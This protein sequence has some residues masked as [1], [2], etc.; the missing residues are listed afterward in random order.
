MGV[1][2]RKVKRNVIAISKV[3]SDCAICARPLQPANQKMQA[4]LKSEEKASGITV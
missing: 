2:G 1:T 3:Q 4:K